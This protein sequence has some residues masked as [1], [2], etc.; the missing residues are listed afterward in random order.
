[1]E[2][3]NNTD[4]SLVRQRV[5]EEEEVATYKRVLGVKLLEIFGTLFLK[6]LE[7]GKKICR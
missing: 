4:L 6:S 1:M 2:R 3:E 7:G 5:H